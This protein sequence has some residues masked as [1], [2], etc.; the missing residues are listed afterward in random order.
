MCLFEKKKGPPH[1]RRYLSCSEKRTPAQLIKSWDIQT[2][3]L[4]L[5]SWIPFHLCF[6]SA[7]KFNNNDKMSKFPV[8][9][10]FEIGVVEDHIDSKLTSAPFSIS[11]STHRMLPVSTAAISGVESWLLSV[12]SSGSWSS[13]RSIHA[14]FLLRIVSINTFLSPIDTWI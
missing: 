9:Q 5:T 11:F 10:A 6:G 14:S 12:F 7:P 4:W 8:S 2:I 3:G 13:S 1:T